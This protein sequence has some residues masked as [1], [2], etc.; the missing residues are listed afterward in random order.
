[1]M[2]FAAMR[3]RNSAGGGG[4]GGTAALLLHFNGTNGATT[5]TDSGANGIAVTMFNGAQISTAQS[6][7]GG[8]SFALNA[9]GSSYLTTADE[10]SLRSGSGDLTIDFRMRAGSPAGGYQTAFVIGDPSGSG[11]TNR[12]E[13]RFADSGFGEAFQLNVGQ[14]TGLGDIQSFGIDKTSAA[15]TWV[16]V[17]TVFTAGVFYLYING[18]RVATFTHALNLTVGAVS[19]GRL[20]PSSTQYFTGYIDE[21]RI[22]Q[23]ALTTGSSYT[24][25]VVE[26]T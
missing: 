13:F 11:G 25:D 4:G 14:G 17:R 20:R 12:L 10:P 7:F 2:P 21:L 22:V 8:S 24:L 3:L 18:T 16:A 19:I 15:N 9:I 5:T 23:T 6:V 1:M 26:F